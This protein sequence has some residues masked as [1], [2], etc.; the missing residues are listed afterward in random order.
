MFSS[1]KL[2]E[3]RKKLGLSQA[4][5]ADK[6]GIS[7]PSYFNWEIGKTKPNQK[8]LDKLAHLLKVDSAYFLSQHDIVEIYTRLNESNKTKTLKYSQHLLEQQDKERNLMKNKRYPYRVYEKLSAGTGYSYFGDGNFDTV[9][10]DEEIDHDFASWIFGDSMEPIFLNGE[11]AL[12]KQTGFDYDGAI[13]AI[14]W[15]G[16]TYIKKVYR[17]KTG[18]RLVSLNKKYADKF[19]PYDENPRIIGLIVGNFIPL[20]G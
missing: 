10:Y 4:Q 5:T 6:L 15:D 20:E 19:A 2:K 9:F 7:R 13:Y 14:D 8:N 16:Q 12:I 3:R 11:V 17:E 18:L 1:Q